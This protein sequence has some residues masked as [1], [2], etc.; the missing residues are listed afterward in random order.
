MSNKIIQKPS[1]ENFDSI[2]AWAE[3]FPAQYPRLHTESEKAKMGDS[4]LV[5][6]TLRLASAVTM[7]API[8]WLE[9]EADIATSYRTFGMCKIFAELATLHS[10]NNTNMQ[11][12]LNDA[13]YARYATFTQAQ[14]RMKRKPDA[15]AFKEHAENMIGDIALISNRALKGDEFGHKTIGALCGVLT[16]DLLAASSASGLF[17]FSQALDKFN[18]QSWKAGRE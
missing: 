16:Y 7:L 6:Q 1:G 10:V 13:T 4:L 2:Q 18:V 15:Q 12:S 9:S 8:E 5:R 3:Y 14:S 17:I 11:D